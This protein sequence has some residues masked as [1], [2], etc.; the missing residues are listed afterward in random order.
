M[1]HWKRPEG[2]LNVWRIVDG[3]ERMEDGSKKPIKFSIQDIPDDESRRQE[4][5]DH[6]YDYF[7]ED[8]PVSKSTKIK[9][10]PDGV[11]DFQ[12][13]WNYALD[14]RVVIGCYKLDSDGK[15][16]KLVGAN[17]VF[18]VTKDSS[19]DM[20]NFK[21]ENFK[22]IWRLFED[23]VSNA[24]VCKIYNVDKY[25]SSISLSVL[26]EYRGQKLGQYI[27]ETRD[28][29]GKKYGFPATSTMFTAAASQRQAERAGFEEKFS[30]NYADIV[31]E[32]GKPQ[33]P[34]ITSKCVKIM[35]KRFAH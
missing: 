12:S 16:D 8:E 22:K 9:Q 21:S 20:K 18:M 6:F 30:K 33:F 13:V 35:M 29:L 2:P 26:P 25:I 7:L 24:D 15:I 1:A 32:N 19:K 14:Q 17:I 11:A 5:L 23:L 27:L 28:D 10:D 3:Y 4:V 31:D 34:N